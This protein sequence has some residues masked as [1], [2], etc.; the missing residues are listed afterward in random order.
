MGKKIK[1]EPFE[2]RR[3]EFAH[4]KVGDEIVSVCLN[5]LNTVGISRLEWDLAGCEFNHSLECWKRKPQKV[6]QLDPR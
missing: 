1:S 2:F 3:L 5:C 4:R 6:S